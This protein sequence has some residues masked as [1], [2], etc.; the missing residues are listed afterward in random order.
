MG[1]G[2]NKAILIGHLGADP[3]AGHMPSGGRVTSCSIATTEVWRD[4]QSGQTQE[5]TEWHRIVFFNRLAEVADEYLRKGAKIY[6]EG[7]LRTRKWQD[8]NGVDHYTTEIVVGQMQMLSGHQKN[9]Q[10]QAGQAPTLKPRGGPQAPQ[11]GRA[12]PAGGGY[13]RSLAGQAHGYQQEPSPMA[14]AGGFENSYDDD[15]PF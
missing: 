15:I 8:Q 6:V 13:G 10:A 9:P 11:Q 5:R 7:R 14:P 3:E 2:I 4:K 12:A 1:R